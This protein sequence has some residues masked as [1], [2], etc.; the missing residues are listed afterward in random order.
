[1][2]D[3]RSN[4]RTFTSV[5]VLCFLSIGGIGI[6][7]GAT[8]T[9]AE[10]LQ[11][12]FQNPP[13]AARPS[14]Y[15][16]WLNGYVNQD[17]IESELRAYAQKG[18][19]GI[20]IFDMGARG[21]QKYAPPAGP[22]FMSK[23]SVEHIAQATETARQL[24]LDV[25]LAACSSWDLGA[26]WVT[27][28]QASMALYHTETR[29]EGPRQLAQKL[30]YPTLPAAVPRNAAGDPV[31]SQ[32]VA[33]LAVREDA[34][35]PG[36]EFLFRLPRGDLHQIDHVVLVNSHCPDPR[37][38]SKL[39]SFSKDFSVAVSTQQEDPTEFQE[40]VSASL[41]AHARP[42][43]F[44]FQN[45]QARFVR[46]RIINGH[47]A[48]SESVQLAEFEVY[49]VDGEN[50]AASKAI[51]RTKDAAEIVDFTSEA[52]AGGNWTVGNLHD[53]ARSRPDGVWS[54]FGPPPLR[55]RRPEDVVDL[56]SSVDQSGELRWQ[57]PDG[58]WTIMRFVCANTGERLKVPSPNSD[59]LATDHFS[60]DATRAFIETLTDR[61]E[62]QMGDLS[63]AGLKQLYLPSYEVVNA[64]WT[65]NF[66]DE[67]RKYRGYEMKPYLPVLAG[68]EMV[69]HE[70]TQRFRFD[71]QKTLG[72]L[73]VDAYYRAAS[74]AAHAAGLGIEAEAGGPGPPVHQVP[75]DALKALGAIDEM[76]GEYWPWRPQ[77]DALWVVKETACAA[78]IYGRKRVHMEAFTG[79]RHW[80]HSPFELKP[81]ADR[82]FC[83]GMNHVVWHTGSHQPP[84][85]GKPGWVYGAGTHLTPNRV[86]W[87]MAKPFLDYLSRCSYLLQQGH[88]VGDVCYYYGDEGANFVPPKHVDPS[89]GPG[90]DYD[91]VN[92]QVILERMSVEDGKIALPGGLR[93][94]LLVLPDREDI[95]LDVLEK[96]Q[97]LLQAGAT[98]VGPK[99]TK[100]NGLA[101]I[102]RRER[103]IKRLG[104]LIWGDCDGKTVLHHK[105]CRGDVFYGKPLREIFGGTE[106]A[107]RFLLR[108]FFLHRAGRFHPPTN[109]RCRHLLHPKC[110]INGRGYCRDVSCIESTTRDLASRDREHRTGCCLRCS[111]RWGSRR[112]PVGAIRCSV[113][114][115]W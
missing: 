56:S 69:N 39:A 25:Q 93:Y 40:V 22:A 20:L 21:D 76:R 61:L 16:L 91:V 36:H 72:D 68:C 37:R 53:G 79:F 60:A 98:V 94:E 31:F 75:V 29:I 104:D 103:K 109:R 62:K 71:F 3:R 96:I 84:E 51:D 102:A 55:I 24:G 87:P 63:A 92:R 81:S 77:R 6:G 54:F 11:N 52:A 42:Q 114:R 74:E 100:S 38:P 32:E 50:V 8:S 28:S 10:D 30:P 45:T 13:R 4:S 113:R 101:N 46:L 49:S 1:M 82:A 2:N 112:A 65:P 66:L 9:P 73:L 80:E 67:F 27:P 83:E 44:D 7:P 78:H 86:W 33:V 110:G 88:F 5:V 35:L 58:K 105:S 106:R 23:E 111:G 90:Y 85:A 95:D 18:I 89:L 41:E 47:S 14:L 43:R 64:K 115:F 108:K 57:V 15:W 17:Y 48:D 99:P 12:G 26:P 97:Q 107:S 19:G 70:H 34:R 59:G